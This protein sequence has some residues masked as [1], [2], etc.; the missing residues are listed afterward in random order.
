M[1]KAV[2]CILIVAL[3]GFLVIATL[4]I[5]KAITS[6]QSLDLDNGVKYDSTISDTMRM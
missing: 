4:I 1:V 6:Q 2:K 5:T 3:V